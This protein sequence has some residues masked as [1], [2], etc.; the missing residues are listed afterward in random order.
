MKVIEDVNAHEVVAPSFYT[1][2]E[3]GDILKL[4][5]GTVRRLFVDEDGVVK[6]GHPE[7]R[8]K[9][10]YFTLQIPADVLERVL[11]R[12]GAKPNRPMRCLPNREGAAP[13][14]HPGQPKAVR[15][16]E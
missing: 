14:P 10:Q 11:V 4:H 3:V 5:P 8:R 6:L 1:P 13:D 16:S 9:R 15:N 2:E 7:T 12:L